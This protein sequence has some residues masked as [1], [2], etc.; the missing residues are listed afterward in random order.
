[1]AK[2]P[3]APG[4]AG[5]GSQAG[6]AGLEWSTLQRLFLYHMELTIL[7][8]PPATVWLHPASSFQNVPGIQKDSYTQGSHPPYPAL[9]TWPALHLWVHPMGEGWAPPLAILADVRPSVLVA[10]SCPSEA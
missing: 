2:H 9:A 6:S 7:N 1:M 10:E 8:R 4:L 3:A 5:S